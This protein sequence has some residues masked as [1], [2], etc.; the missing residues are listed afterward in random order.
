MG[1]LHPHDLGY[2]V[3]PRKF[4]PLF[5]HVL[6][7]RTLSSDRGHRGSQDGPAAGRSAS[8]RGPRTG[9][10]RPPC[11]AS[12]QGGPPR[13]RGSVL[14]PFGSL[15]SLAAK[16]LVNQLPPGPYYGILAEFA[17]PADLY[18]ACE[19]VRDAGFTRWD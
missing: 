14:M 10:P 18:H 5:H 1:L 15:R 3:S 11:H 19:R 17:T 7:V 13:I 6:P 8:S 2:L 12:S 4:R 16:P 9:A